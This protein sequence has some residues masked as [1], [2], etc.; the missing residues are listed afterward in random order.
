[1]GG[2]LTCLFVIYLEYIKITVTHTHTLW[3]A[4]RYLLKDLQPRTISWDWFPLGS[5]NNISKLQ[6]YYQTSA[7]ADFGPSIWNTHILPI[8]GLF[9]YWKLNLMFFSWPNHM[10]VGFSSISGHSLLRMIFNCTLLKNNLKSISIK[11]VP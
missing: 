5:S 4:I 8:K 1:M 2:Q 10:P 11:N 3:C 6:G 7:H 9:S